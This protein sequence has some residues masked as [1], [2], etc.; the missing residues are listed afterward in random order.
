MDLLKDYNY[1]P[2]T[3]HSENHF[4]STIKNAYKNVSDFVKLNATSYGFMG[5]LH[6]NN[7]IP[8]IVKGKF[9]ILDELENTYHTVIEMVEDNVVDYSFMNLLNDKGYVQVNGTYQLVAANDN[10]IVKKAA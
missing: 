7:Y 10:F 4:L 9:S 2:E 3:D 6:D 1:V 8:Q 5:L